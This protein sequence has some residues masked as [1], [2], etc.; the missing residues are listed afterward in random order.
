MELTVRS[1][2]V[3]NNYEEVRQTELTDSQPNK[4]EDIY[5]SLQYPPPSTVNVP[6]ETRWKGKWILWLSILGA[7]ILIILTVVAVFYF[8]G[9]TETLSL[10]ER[11]SWLLHKDFFY[12]L[13]SSNVAD[14]DEAIQFCASR[15]ATLAAVNQDNRD[16]L[17]K[18]A[19]GRWFILRSE[20]EGFGSGSDSGSGMFMEDDS[21]FLCELLHSDPSASPP[22]EHTSALCVRKAC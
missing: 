13:K 16:W 14:C 22:F 18:M 1:R 4:T 19:E 3:S 5:Q 17:L 10:I 8:M 12:L 7:V 21:D 15:N 2:V 9:R 11:E 20:K 6:P